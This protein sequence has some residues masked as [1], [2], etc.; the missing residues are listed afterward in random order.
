MFAKIL[1]SPAA[2][3]HRYLIVF[4]AWASTSNA[5]R[6]CRGYSCMMFTTQLFDDLSKCDSL[7]L[8]AANASDYGKY[9]YTL[10]L[11]DV[12]LTRYHCI[13]YVLLFVGASVL[14]Y[15]MTCHVVCTITVAWV[16]LDA[17]ANCKLSSRRS[18]LQRQILSSL[19]TISSFAVPS[20]LSSKRYS[21]TTPVRG[22]HER[23]RA[24][25]CAKY[26]WCCCHYKQMLSA[27]TRDKSAI[28]TRLDTMS[29]SNK[30]ENK[31]SSTV[32]WRGSK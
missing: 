21:L 24:L 29:L 22:D 20:L 12:R 26:K 19:D 23:K 8:Y 30:P 28:A 27:S 31:L 6:K 1:R 11:S 5:S 3:N 17:D 2:L 16:F 10:L 25:S 13:A 9:G 18:E 15:R 7:L 32:I 4:A 14:L